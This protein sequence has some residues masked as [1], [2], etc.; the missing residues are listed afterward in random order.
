L[1][2]FIKG[3]F[4]AFNRSTQP[5]NGFKHQISSSLMRYSWWLVLFIVNCF[6]IKHVFEHNSNPFHPKI[7]L[8]VGNMAQFLYIC[9]YSIT[10]F[11]HVCQHCC[12]MNSFIWS[13]QTYFTLKNYIWHSKE[14]YFHLFCNIINKWQLIE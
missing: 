12:I 8:W 11:E 4:Y 2:L 7:F 1:R 10:K 3:L 6:R 9:S 14:S 5:S 13:F